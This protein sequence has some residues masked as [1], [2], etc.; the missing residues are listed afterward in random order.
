MN[1]FDRKP[2]TYEQ[3]LGFSVHAFW[4]VTLVANLKGVVTVNCSNVSR[5]ILLEYETLGS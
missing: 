3:D 4:R 1:S 5:W 2:G